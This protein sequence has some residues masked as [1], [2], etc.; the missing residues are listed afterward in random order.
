MVARNTRGDPTYCL[1]AHARL[2]A[3]RVRPGPVPTFRET[4]SAASKR[5]AAT[6]TAVINAQL[7]EGL[8]E[9][10]GWLVAQQPCHTSKRMCDSKHMA[11]NSSCFW[12]CG[13]QVNI[14]AMTR[15]DVET[16]VA[17]LRKAVP[18]VKVLR[19]KVGALHRCIKHSWT[20]G[21]GLW[22]GSSGRTGSCIRPRR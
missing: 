16:F 22:Q 10:G 8:V 2:Q 15:E 4:A 3:R 17:K 5:T 21:L 9:V 20:A 18:R 12:A 13:M 1:L 11:L 6:K 14:A 7:A 19:L